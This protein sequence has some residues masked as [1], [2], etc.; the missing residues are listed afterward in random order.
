MV[1]GAAAHRRMED[2]NK[3]MTKEVHFCMPRMASCKLP[4]GPRR[5]STGAMMDTLI[6]RT[7][8]WAPDA[9][10]TLSVVVQCAHKNKRRVASPAGHIP[11]TT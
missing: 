1:L 9:R 5:A 8:A 3:T 4:S 10:E 2:R 11:L 6:E 7:T